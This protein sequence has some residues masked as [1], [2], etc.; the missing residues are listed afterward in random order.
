MTDT[1]KTLRA[2]AKNLGVT[3]DA[4]R[5]DSGWGFWLLDSDGNGLWADDNF[6]TSHAEIDAKLNQYAEIAGA[7]D[8]ALIRAVREF[9]LLN[10]N[11]GGWDFLVECWADADIAETIAGAKTAAAAIAR[12]KRILSVLDE[13]RAEQMA[14][15]NW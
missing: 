4:Q 1:L 3:I 11:I 6:C 12:C 5:D 15:A 10:Y 13:H 7:A 8:P 9:A 2:K 14:V